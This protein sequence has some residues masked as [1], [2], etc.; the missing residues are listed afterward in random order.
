[1]TKTA[2]G[3]SSSVLRPTVVDDD[4]PVGVSIREMSAISANLS[5]SIPDDP[6]RIDAKAEALLTFSDGGN[7]GVAALVS[8][9]TKSTGGRPRKVDNDAGFL[10]KRGLTDWR[11]VKFYAEAWE[12]EVGRK[13]EL[14]EVVMLPDKP[15]PKRTAEIDLGGLKASTSV[16][17]YTPAPYIEAARSVMGGIDLDPASCE[18]ANE[19]VQAD[20]YFAMDDDPDGLS[21]DW[22]GR[23]WLNPPYGKGT[24]L[25]VSK[26]AEEWNAERIDAAVLLINAYG[27]DARWYAPLWDWPICFTHHRIEFYS[28]DHESGG[29][30]NGN[31]FVYMGPDARSF[32]AQ[33][34]QFGNIV[35]RWP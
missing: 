14:G 12:T 1:V 27:F 8:A 23:V 21:Q 5:V 22:F 2:S 4:S 26:L 16:E 28:P 11:T 29:P 24:G 13:P 33:F 32:A 34:A 31:V 6:E 30:A 35:R 10:K 9:R 3:L 25:F 18:I 15:F 19:I 7:W 20:T 17:W